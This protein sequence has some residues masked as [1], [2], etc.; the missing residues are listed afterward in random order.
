MRQ[1]HLDLARGKI[2][3][4]ADFAKYDSVNTLVD[5]SQIMA[6]NKLALIFVVLVLA[7]CSYGPPTAGELKDFDSVCDKANGGKRIAVIGY[8]RFPD[9]ITGNQSGVLRPSKEP[10]F[11]GTPIGVQTSFG[12]S[13]NHM[14]LPPSRYTGGFVHLA[15]GQTIGVRTKV[16]VSGKI[17]FPLIGQD[18]TCSLESPLFELAM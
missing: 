2:L 12:S 13:P 6:S 15:D 8:P 4:D 7:A 11:K 1:C 10:D 5:E 17:Y 9:K 16:K 14:E 18:F 3:K